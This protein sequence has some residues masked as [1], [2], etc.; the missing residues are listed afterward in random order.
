MDW[1][2]GEAAGEKQQRF[3]GEDFC[4]LSPLSHYVAS[5]MVCDC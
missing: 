5:S 3:P 2:G 1:K 4:I